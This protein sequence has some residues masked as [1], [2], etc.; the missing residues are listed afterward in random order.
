DFTIVLLGAVEQ[1]LLPLSLHFL[2]ATGLTQERLK[3][4]RTTTNLLRL[5]RLLRLMRL[6]RLIRDIPPLHTLAVGILESLQGMTWVFLLALLVLYSCGIMCT[7]LIGHRLLVGE[8]CPQAVVDIFPHV[9][10]SMFVLFKVMNADAQVLDPLFE[11]MQI[12]KMITAYFMILAN[13]AILAILTAVVSENLINAC[14]PP[15]TQPG[16]RRIEAQAARAASLSCFEKAMETD[17]SFREY[18]EY[19]EMEEGNEVELL[20]AETQRLGFWQRCGVRLLCLTLLCYFLPMLSFIPLAIFGGVQLPSPWDSGYNQGTPVQVAPPAKE[21]PS[22]RWYWN[23]PLASMVLIFFPLTVVAILYH[24][25]MR[26]VRRQQMIDSLL[27][28]E[29]V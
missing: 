7:Q 26:A 1:W 21:M 27:S 17:P 5:L 2:H 19:Q 14:A 29:C 22:G 6:L 16:G 20:P 12:S 3:V 11:Y 4:N 13:W 23:L 9:G 10:E 15:G 25:K 28:A 24:L 8:D 18:R